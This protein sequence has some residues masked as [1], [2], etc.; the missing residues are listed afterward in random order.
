MRIWYRLL[1]QTLIAFGFKITA[2]ILLFFW[3]IITIT[4]YLIN[5]IELTIAWAFMATAIGSSLLWIVKK[6][7]EN[8]SSFIEKIGTDVTNKDAITTKGVYLHEIQSSILLSIR[9]IH[10]RDEEFLN[11]TS[12]IRHSASELTENAT[13]LAGNTLEQSKAT[14]AIAQAITDIGQR[15]DMV[16]ERVEDVREAASRTKALSYKGHKAITEV[17]DEILKMSD[18][19]VNTNTLINFL[20]QQSKQV[21]EMSKVIEDIANQTNLLALNAA[22]EAARAGEQGRGF[23]VV[24]DEVRSLAIKSHGASLDISSNIDNIYKEMQKASS[25]MEGVV[26]R[27]ESCTY[28]INSAKEQLVKITEHSESVYQKIDTI[29]ENSTH[30]SSSTTKIL[31]HINTVVEKSRENSNK[32]K[33]SAS[34]SA[35]LYNLTSSFKKV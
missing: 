19:A 33:E 9:N 15:I 5:M 14:D 16:G 24:A 8:L 3:L 6:D 34:V 2:I 20:E 28:N 4:S 30:Q 13:S 32:A 12:E 31:N 29:S 22:I 11:I 17:S 21:A 27:A 7:I 23:A 35:Y 25:S 10:R 1:Q 18:L 26:V